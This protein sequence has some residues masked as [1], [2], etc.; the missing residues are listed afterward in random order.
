MGGHDAQ[1]VNPCRSLPVLN[2][3]EEMLD[4]L[5]TQ[6]KTFPQFMGVAASGDASFN[7]FPGHE[8]QLFHAFRVDEAGTGEVVLNVPH[9]LSPIPRR[10]ERVEFL[11]D[12]YGC[13]RGRAPIDVALQVRVPERLDQETLTESLGQVG[14]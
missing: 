14:K 1:R 6:K 4:L 10:T 8:R 11:L 2:K 9:A 5:F 13:R 3:V 12:R 7:L